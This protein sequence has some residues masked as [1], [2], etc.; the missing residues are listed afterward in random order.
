MREYQARVPGWVLGAFV[1]PM[2]FGGKAR[3]ELC[4]D[5]TS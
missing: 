5:G 2:A 1:S 4:N 3:R